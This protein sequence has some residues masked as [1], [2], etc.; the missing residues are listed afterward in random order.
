[1]L[2]LAP[3]LT[4]L[5]LMTSLTELISQFVHHELAKLIYLTKYHAPA[6]S[7]AKSFEFL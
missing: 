6:Q 2:E 5:K 1:M 4:E 3:K 7:N